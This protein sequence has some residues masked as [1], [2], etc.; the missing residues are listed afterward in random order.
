[1]RYF[2]LKDFS[3]AYSRV[4]KSISIA[5]GCLGWENNLTGTYGAII[6]Y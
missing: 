4:L 5:L 6:L 2:Y 3:K 1:M